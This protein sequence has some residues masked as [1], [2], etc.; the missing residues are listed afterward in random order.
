LRYVLVFDILFSRLCFQ[1]E[2][3]EALSM[4]LQ[5]D[6]RSQSKKIVELIRRQGGVDARAALI[7]LVKN[8]LTDDS[9][10]LLIKLCCEWNKT[11][12]NNTTAQFVM[13][14]VFLA[15]SADRLTKSTALKAS[16]ES[17]LAFSHR[18]LTRISHLVSSSFVLD[19]CLELMGGV[20]DAA[21]VQ[22]VDT[23]EDETT[24]SNK[25]MRE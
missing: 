12:S 9:L 21:D 8:R 1:G 4:A 23:N 10:E 14:A 17:W 11:A 18:H 5:L 20:L 2:L 25:R 13:E 24:S 15:L 16:L 22:P 7:E 3:V 6:H 19:H